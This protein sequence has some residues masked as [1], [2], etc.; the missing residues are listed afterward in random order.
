MVTVREVPVAENL[1]E[2]VFVLKVFASSIPLS[3]HGKDWQ[4]QRKFPGGAEQREKQKLPWGGQ[5]TLPKAL[6]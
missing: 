4:V 2:S 5:E 6:L 1:G 3:S